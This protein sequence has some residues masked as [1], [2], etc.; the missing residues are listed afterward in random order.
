MAKCFRCKKTM[1]DAMFRMSKKKDKDG[2]FQRVK[3]CN[4]CDAKYQIDQKKYLASEKGKKNKV[5]KLESSKAY[6]RTAA[7]QE[8]KKRFYAEQD[9]ASL[10]L[11]EGIDFSHG[12]DP[13]GTRYP[14]SMV[15]RMPTRAARSHMRAR[16][17]R[18]RGLIATRLAVQDL[19]LALFD[20]AEYDCRR[21]DEW[22]A[23]GT[24][25]SRGVPARAL[26]GK[27][28]EHAGSDWIECRMLEYSADDDTTP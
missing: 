11:H 5:R 18:H 28:H 21:L 1:G 25:E 3:V 9:L 10:L 12:D 13:G 7:G 17:A 26:W 20:N 6:R 15:S 27:D 16:H 23:M 2:V 8:Y 4:D 14:C 24:A 22:I 19:P